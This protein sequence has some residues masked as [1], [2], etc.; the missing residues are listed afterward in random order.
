MRRRSWLILV[1]VTGALQAQTQFL[2]SK[3]PVTQGIMGVDAQS[4]ESSLLAAFIYDYAAGGITD[5]L[6]LTATHDTVIAEGRSFYEFD[7]RT[8]QFLRR[9]PALPAPYATWAFHG[10][11]ITAE[12][13]LQLGIASGFYGV[14]NCPAGFDFP[15]GC[16]APVTWFP[17]YPDSTEQPRTNILLR[18]GFAANDVSIEHVTTFAEENQLPRYTTID[19]NSREFWFLYDTRKNGVET[20]RITRAPI[21]NGKVLDEAVVRE[22]L[23]DTT[24]PS[25]LRVALSFTRD[26][27]SDS[28]LGTFLFVAQHYESALL[29]I[30]GMNEVTLQRVP[31]DQRLSSITTSETL[32]PADYV[33]IVPVIAD[34][35][36]RNGSYWNSDVWLYNPS[37]QTVPVRIARVTLPA[38]ITTISLAPHSSVALR[39]ALR[40]LGGGPAGDATPVDGLILQTPYAMPQLS[41]TSR[42]YTNGLAGGIV[43]HFVPAVPTTAGYSNHNSASQNQPDV[44]ETQAVFLLDKRQPDQYR[45]NIGIV[46]TGESPLIVRL[47]YAIVSP[48][49]PNDPARDVSLSVPPHIV[50]EYPLET[51]FPPDVVNTLPG[52]VWVTAD[53][54]A[55]M[56]LSII[57]NTSNDATFIP[58][59]FYGMQEVGGT[60]LTVPR[61]TH[62]LHGN[63]MWTTDIFGVF[64]GIG[65]TTPQ[66]PAATFHA[67]SGTTCVGSGNLVASQH[68]P[69]SSTFPSTPFWNSIFLDVAAQVCPG[70]GSRTGSLDLA[71]GSWTSAAA[72]TSG[73]LNGVTVADVLPLFPP[74]G[75]PERHFAGIDQHPGITFS[76]GLYNGMD[77]DAT[78]EI[79]LYGENGGLAGTREV[80]IGRRDIVEATLHDLFGDQPDGLYAIS[81]LPSRGSCWPWVSSTDLLSG[82][83]TS[84]W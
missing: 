21:A 68:W 82:D 3:T 53:R 66:H 51:L 15:Y 31:D 72:R 33:Q 75:W 1:L 71:T 22:Q 25:S 18:R 63:R 76:I 62:A 60:P 43:S 34:A 46:N 30:V 52:R 57:D 7:Q 40:F 16:V 11:A 48:G 10:I 70:D 45:H 39:K 6:Q 36:G 27:A 64:S 80:T 2:L 24:V 67:Q 74:R 13:A 83:I 12:R 77:E 19:S 49:P 38:T 47:R 50:A 59:T 20:E 44:V 81:F 17:G 69:I 4:G 28:F 8:G 37:E 32:P 73:T 42:T 54:A 65:A 61:V 79:R 26:A 55:P 9:Y 78:V 14:P 84:Y 56:W 23:L 35:Q 41:V 5:H 29:R 58:F